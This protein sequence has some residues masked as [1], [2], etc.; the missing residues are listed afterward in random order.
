MCTHLYIIEFKLLHQPSTKCTSGTASVVLAKAHRNCIKIL[1]K[2]ITTIKALV[3]TTVLQ[4]T[5]GVELAVPIK[6]ASL[7]RHSLAKSLRSLKEIFI[8]ARVPFQ[9][10]KHCRVSAPSSK[11]YLCCHSQHAFLFDVWA[12]ES[13]VRQTRDSILHR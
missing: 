11:P 3:I 10:N 9:V 4:T 6:S 1:D 7:L 8:T 13:M 12:Q 5:E 2:T